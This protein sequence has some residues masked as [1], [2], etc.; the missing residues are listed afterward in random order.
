MLIK[1]RFGFEDAL[2]KGQ[3]TQCTRLPQLRGLGRVRCMQPFP[4]NRGVVSQF[5]PMT[6]K[7]QRRNFTVAARLTLKDAYKI[8]YANRV[9]NPRSFRFNQT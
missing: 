3:R 4:E 8:R 1:D 9:T 6:S 5:E 7:L 2:D